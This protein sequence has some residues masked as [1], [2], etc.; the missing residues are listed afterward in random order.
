[1]SKEVVKRECSDCGKKFSSLIFIDM[2]NKSVC[3]HC[4]SDNYQ[5][6]D[7]CNRKMNIKDSHQ[8][9]D[10]FDYACNICIQKL[11]KKTNNLN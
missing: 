2:D 4:Y 8:I 3:E 11:A 1:M 7:V 5:S 10:S 6:C 9:G